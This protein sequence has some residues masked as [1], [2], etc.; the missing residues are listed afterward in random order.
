MY[1]WLSSA[2]FTLQHTASPEP[3]KVLL[4]GACALMLSRASSCLRDAHPLTTSAAATNTAQRPI[5]CVNFELLTLDLR[6]RYGRAPTLRVRPMLL[7][8]RFLAQPARSLVR[9]SAWCSFGRRN[10]L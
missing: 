2:R 10:I 3:A 5:P 6:S 1:P 7:G 9:P 4:K 8:I